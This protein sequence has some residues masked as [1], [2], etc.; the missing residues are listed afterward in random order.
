M[1][2]APTPDWMSALPA[3]LVH[4]STMYPEEYWEY[5]QK[6]HEA[7]QQNRQALQ[8]FWQQAWPEYSEAQRNAARLGEEHRQRYANYDQ[9]MRNLLQ[10]MAD[11]NQQ[12][13]VPW[14]QWT[15]PFM[16]GPHVE[17]SPF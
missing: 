15:K 11:Y 16:P 12:L 10:Q 17:W 4:L 1:A 2:S 14:A 7:A 13:A 9:L 6:Q 3:A 8:N 5:L